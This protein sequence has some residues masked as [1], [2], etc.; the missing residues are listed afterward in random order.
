MRNSAAQAWNRNDARAAKALSLRGQSENELM[1]QAHRE[2]AR[3][4]YDE[5]N[6][7][8]PASS[9]G[10]YFIDLHGLH[11]GEAV[12]QVERVLGDDRSRSLKGPS[13]PPSGRSKPYIYIIVGTGHHS[14]NGRDKIGKAVRTYLQ[15]T[16]YAYREFSLPGESNGGGILGVDLRTYD[17]EKVRDQTATI[18][19]DLRNGGGVAREEHQGGGTSINQVPSLTAA[20]SASASSPF[21]ATTA[22]H[23]KIRILTRE[24]V[25]MEGSR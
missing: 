22:S 23:A 5:R 18:M 24:E 13:S 4:L 25:L 10:E 9:S 15:E 1:R 7:S 3:Q 11:P 20:V 8:R 12:E 14:R 16:G 17:S 6:P 21:S 2:A 19:K